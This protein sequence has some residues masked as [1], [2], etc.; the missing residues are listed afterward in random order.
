M[1]S[2]H[3]DILQRRLPDIRRDLRVKYVIPQLI[4]RCILLPPMG[5]DIYS[6]ETQGE[7]VDEL[8]CLLKTRGRTA[9]PVF[10]KVLQETYP[11]L[12]DLLQEEG[13]ARPILFIIHA[14]EDKKPFVRPLHKALRGQN[15]SDEEIFF[16]E[17]SIST[18][19]NISEKIMS[20]L[21]SEIL[22][23]VTIVI[24]NHLLDKYWPRL[25]YEKSLFHQKK[26]YPIWLDQNTDNFEAFSRKV[27]SRF[28][29]LK[30]TLAHRIQYDNIAEDI[31]DVAIEIVQLLSDQCHP[32]NVTQEMSTPPQQRSAQKGRQLMAKLDVGKHQA[33][34][35]AA[36]SDSVAI[37]V[38]YLSE[39]RESLQDQPQKN[40]EQRGNE[41][42]E[43]QESVENIEEEERFAIIESRILRL[44]NRMALVEDTKKSAD[45]E[46]MD[47]NSN[48]WNNSI[49]ASTVGTDT[50]SDHIQTGDELG[51]ALLEA[52]A[53]LLK[54]TVIPGNIVVHLM[55]YFHNGLGIV[56]TIIADER[57]KG[58][59]E[60][61]QTL[62]VKL[63]TC[64]QPGWFQAFLN[65]LDNSGY[66]HIKTIMEGRETTKNF[67]P[68]K[69]LLQLWA[70]Q[71]Q[72]AVAMEMLPHLPC[73]SDQD[74]EQVETENR[75]YG[76]SRALITLI[77]RVT[78]CGPGWYTQ[79]LEGLRR[80]K[81]D[82]LADEL[83]DIKTAADSEDDTTVAEA[84]TSIGLDALREETGFEEVAEKQEEED[85]A[86]VLPGTDGTDTKSEPIPA[87]DELGKALLEAFAP[88][89]KDTVIPGNIVVHLMSYFD[90]GLGFVRTIIADERN[91]GPAEA[92]QTLL[93]KL[94]TCE[95]PGW[96]QA[97]LNSLENS[98]YNFIKTIMEGRETIQ[99]MTP[100][101]RLLQLWAPQLQVVVAMEMLPHL[102]C[103]SDQDKDQIEAENHSHGNTRAL[104]TLIDRVTRFP[105]GWYR[106]FLQGLRRTKHDDLA[107]E[108]A[109][110]RVHM[111]VVNKHEPLLCET[112]VSETPITIGLDAS[113][114]EQPS[115]TA[116]FDE[117][118]EKQ[119]DEGCEK[120]TPLQD[121]KPPPEQSEM[122][123]IPMRGYQVELAM[124]AL[125]GRNTIICA[126]TGSGKTRVAIKI[127]RDHLEGGA[128]FEVGAGVDA[129]RR[130]VFLVNKVPLVEQQCNAFREY[131]SPKYDILPLSGE[132][133]ADIPVGETL[134]EH[135]VIILTAQ[136]LENAL[137]DELI[138]LDTFSM[139]IFDE[140]H[141]CQK[142]DPY[143]AI[144]TTY[145]KQKV[146]Q[147]SARLPQIIGLTASLGVGKAK[148]QK[149]AVEHILGA[150]ANLDAEWISQV[151]EHKAELQYYNQK[152]DEGRGRAEGSKSV[153]IAGREGGNVLKEKGMR[154]LCVKCKEFACNVSDFRQIKEN[155]HVVV[156]KTF[157][158]RI[159]IKPHPPKK[160]DDWA[161]GMNGKVYCR[162]CR[163]D[164]GIQM[165]YRQA[166]FPTLKIESFVIEKSDGQR[167]TCRKWKN[168][169]FYVDDITPDDISGMLGTPED[170]EEEEPMFD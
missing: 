63:Q 87:T 52:F 82:G 132:T 123:D 50:T 90:N 53:P 92:M 84:L 20:T 26:F 94:Q 7:R 54:E 156:D 31:T 61:M 143:N 81:H 103:L 116:G 110:D 108:L 76:N 64:E 74:K 93:L 127:T 154:L 112:I 160:I 163:Q 149:E 134:P 58:P 16:D 133:A 12:A 49:A 166:S 117:F 69:R 120:M 36:E 122:K 135:D 130:V 126:P 89:L 100:L 107:D 138:T 57:N 17:V 39:K 102:P 145:I 162:N 144:M 65:S 158:H 47:A 14:G 23:L 95:Q 35:Q 5:M 60:G 25:E 109:M 32:D 8:I 106:Q 98:G 15:L 18:G 85:A 27:G 129:R 88:L 86:D 3:R 34:E 96:F 111:N 59:A 46:S 79:F 37:Q 131:L 13:D 121:A 1:E 141:H 55:G 136:V 159:I 169:P 115:A 33:A 128:A 78:R 71:L 22:K 66:S 140:C 105:P 113:N 9:F 139:L 152:P 161:W 146:E 40:N 19:E 125:E 72:V 30:K 4:E 42:K 70:P 155:Y 83:E 67:T 150:C 77:D 157:P 2:K 68:L 91:K 119:D 44:E 56:R 6:K 151:M 118:A 29:L 124:P 41:W 153:L 148:S 164:W 170:E 51:K 101:K 45:D 21:A 147:S 137:R 165:V 75:F 48:P 114:R 28:P 168:A 99:D 24:S 142:N 10:C 38:R 104:I 73:L 167:L 62:L 43:R 97:F 80:S 11:H